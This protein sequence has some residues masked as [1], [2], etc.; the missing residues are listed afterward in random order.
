MLLNSDSLFSQKADAST[1]ITAGI[2]VIGALLGI[3][4][5]IR[6]I[7]ICFIM[8]KQTNRKAYSIVKTGL[9]AAAPSVY[10]ILTLLKV[11]ISVPS[12]VFIAISVAMFFIVVIWNIKTYHILGGIAFSVVHGVFGALACLGVGMLVF[13]G[14]F[15]VVMVF[16]GAS[17]DPVTGPP[18]APSTVPSTVRDVKT[19]MTY[20]VTKGFNG[21]PYIEDHGRSCLLRTSDYPGRYFDDM[22]NEYISC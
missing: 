13:V 15:L 7:R 19:N 11:D 12:S 1:F 5:F 18:S 6:L 14:I 9:I 16:V 22:G 3:F 21:L 17:S 10:T 2:A 4:L 8:E 20:H